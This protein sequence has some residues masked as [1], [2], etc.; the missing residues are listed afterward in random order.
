MRSCAGDLIRHLRNQL[1]MVP[2][3]KFAGITQA[4][5]RILRFNAQEEFVSAGAGEIGS[6]ENR[7][8]RLRQS[9]QQASDAPSTAHSNVTG[10]N[11]GQ[12][13]NGLP[14]ALMG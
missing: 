1:R 3:Q 2:F 8:V 4:E 6:I 10:I 14:P 12:E 13:W 5:M 11:A 7:M 9:I